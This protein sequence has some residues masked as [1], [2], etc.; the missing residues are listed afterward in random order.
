MAAAKA[1]GGEA[2]TI[3]LAAAAEA[4]GCGWGAGLAVTGAGKGARGM[5]AAGAARTGWLGPA[6]ACAGGDSVTRTGG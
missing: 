6:L 5:G 3:G 2:I 4:G 1:A